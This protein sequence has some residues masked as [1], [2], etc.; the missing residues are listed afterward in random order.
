MEDKEKQMAVLGAKLL[1][2]PK[3]GIESADAIRLRS[4]GESA[5]LSNISYSTERGMEQCLKWMAMWEGAN[6]EDVEVTM[7]RDFM[8]T[9]LDPNTLSALVKAW[10]D[11]ALTDSDLLDNLKKGEIASMETK[12]E[13]LK[14][15]APAPVNQPPVNNND[16]KVND[17]KVEK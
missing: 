15:P 10:K 2:T 4:S 1:E 17:P 3:A 12:P 9:K 7:N 5:A 14:K 8:D 6:P 11:G 13:D 16:P